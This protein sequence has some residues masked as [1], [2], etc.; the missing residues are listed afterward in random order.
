M[1]T[2]VR[3]PFLVMDFPGFPWYEMFKISCECCVC[4]VVEWH[5]CLVND[6]DSV[7][8]LCERRIL[9]GF[10]GAGT[11]SEEIVTYNYDND[12]FADER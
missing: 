7:L 1:S 3:S 12:G 8:D 5:C 11:C 10:C 2:A 9:G 6:V 4:V